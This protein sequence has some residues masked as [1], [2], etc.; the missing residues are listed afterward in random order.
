MLTLPHDLSDLRLA[1]TLLALDARLSELALL[2]VD[3]LTERIAIESDRPDWTPDMRRSGLLIA[4]AHFIDLNG[5]TLA[6]DARGLRVK[7]GRYHVVLGVPD[8]FTEYVER[9]GAPVR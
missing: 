7:H 5:W 1:P 9:R 2:D 6:W 4:T 3:E 8:T